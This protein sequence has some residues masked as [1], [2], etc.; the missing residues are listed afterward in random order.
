MLRQYYI[1]TS[2]NIATFP[3][4]SNGL[5]GMKDGCFGKFDK[6]TQIINNDTTPYFID[7]LLSYTN[8]NIFIPT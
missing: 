7:F 4:K 6:E 1:F 8:R 2:I 5:F 3:A